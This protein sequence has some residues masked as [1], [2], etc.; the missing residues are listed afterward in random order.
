MQVPNRGDFIFLDFDPQI[1][2]EQSGRRP[3]IVLSP[4]RFNRVTGYVTVCPISDTNRE[5]GF[6]INI[7][8]GFAV[9]GVIIS[10]QVKNLDW[11]TRNAQIK[12]KASNDL[13]NKVVQVIHTYVY[14]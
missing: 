10:D 11:R 7:P 2:T 13:I 3:A 12:G 5:W 4:E 14:E 1:G 6:H 9:E 8:E